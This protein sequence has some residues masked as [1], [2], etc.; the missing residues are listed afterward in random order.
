MTAR[1]GSDP[2]RVRAYGEGLEKGIVDEPNVFKISTKNAGE[3]GL[4]LAIE[5]PSEALMKCQDNKDGTATV[6]YVPTEE[7]DYDIAVKFNDQHIPGSPF[8]V[9]NI[10]E[11][12][13]Q[14]LNR[15]PGY[16]GLSFQVPAETRDG[17]PKVDPG[18]V[19][20]YGPGLEPGQVLPGK[21]TN[22]KVDATETGPAPLAVDIR[23]ERGHR[24]PK[25]P[26]ILENGDGTFDVSYVPPPVG[27][28]Y[29]VLFRPRSKERLLMLRTYFNSVLF[30]FF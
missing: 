14:D 17:K 8:R 7:G 29:Q 4:G 1:Y 18:K 21:P 22:F 13:P 11:K 24:V 5:G 19:R 20:A 23:N 6:E 2:N 30:F 25:R 9:W 27:E 16:Y 3:G 15:L 28:P 10:V 26:S 12:R